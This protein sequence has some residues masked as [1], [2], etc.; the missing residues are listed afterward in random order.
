MIELDQPQVT[1]SLRPELTPAVITIS[2]QDRQGVSAAAF[3][4][5]AA[6]GVQILDVEQSQFRGF[7][8]LAVFAGVEAAGVETLEIGLKETL[9]TYGQSVKIEL[10]EVAQSSRPRSTHEVVIL[11][12]PV[13]ALMIC[14]V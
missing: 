12:D 5:L 8:G 10:Q 1:V 11:G 13:E 6:N 7:L 9:K 3:R 2:G 14:R 4:V